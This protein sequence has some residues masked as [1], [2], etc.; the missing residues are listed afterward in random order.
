MKRAIKGAQV[1]GLAIGAVE[2]SKGGQSELSPCLTNKKLSPT[3]T[4]QKIGMTDM[5]LNCHMPL[6]NA[7]RVAFFFIGTTFA[8]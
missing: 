1:A 7:C 3:V 4:N 5:V 2:I 6:G 8:S